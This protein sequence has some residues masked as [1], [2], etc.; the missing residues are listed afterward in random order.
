MRNEK[1]ES[2]EAIELRAHCVYSLVN[3]IGEAVQSGFIGSIK[4]RTE[5]W[6]TIIGFFHFFRKSLERSVDGQIQSCCNCHVADLK[7]NIIEKCQIKTV[8]I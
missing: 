3:A 1:L 6:V 8:G 5:L 4:Q 2:R 7:T